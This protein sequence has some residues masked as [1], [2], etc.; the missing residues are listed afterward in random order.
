MYVCMYVYVYV[1]VYI[2][3]YIYM[4]YHIILNMYYIYTSNL[5]YSSEAPGSRAR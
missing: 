5:H 4:K 1:Y 2:Y 3:I